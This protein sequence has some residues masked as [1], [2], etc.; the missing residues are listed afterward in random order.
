MK[1]LLREVSRCFLSAAVLTQS[2]VGAIVIRHDVSDS[3]YRVSSAEFPQIAYLPG[4]GHGVLVA[5]NWVLT[6]AHATTWRRIHELTINGITRTVEKVVVHPGYEKPPKEIQSG[7]AAALIEFLAAS[8]DIALIKLQQPV[9]DVTPVKIYKGSGESGQAVEIIGA[10]ATGNGLVGQYPGSPHRGEL[11]H[12][13][14]RV[15]STSE[16]WL[17]LSFEAPPN[18]LPREGMPADGDSGAPVLLNMQGRQE[19]AGI[20][21]HKFASGELSKF[22]CCVYGQITYQV[23]VSRYAD[24]IKGVISGKQL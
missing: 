14:A 11:R 13:Q 6:A 15:T 3:E 5:T 16:R 10:G 9:N 20:V 12:A 4:E 18:A 7:N 8:D 21:S 23:R 2:W 24:W 19:L 22:R 17:E 1:R